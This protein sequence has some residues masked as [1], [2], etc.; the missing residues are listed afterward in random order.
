VT[1]LRIVCSGDNNRVVVFV[2]NRIYMAIDGT[3]LV[4]QSYDDEIVSLRD[5][6]AR[7]RWLC[8]LVGLTLAIPAFRLARPAGLPPPAFVAFEAAVASV[9]STLVPG[10]FCTPD[11]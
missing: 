10:L 3:A 5:H 6:R 11:R 2:V 1:I 8:L 9:A 4:A 7:G